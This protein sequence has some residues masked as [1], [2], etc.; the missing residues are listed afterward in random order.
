M[1][2]AGGMRILHLDSG[3]EMRGGQWQVC[4][5]LDGL[6]ARGVNGTLLA[7]ADGPLYELARRQGWHVEPLSVRRALMALGSHDVVHAHDARMHTWASLMGRRPLV[8]SRRV[9]FPVKSRWKYA[10]ADRYL[11]VSHY[12]KSVLVAAGISEDRIAVV[13]D[14]VPVLE[15]ARP[16]IVMAP[17]NAHDPMKGAPLVVAAARAGGIPVHYSSNLEQDLTRASLFVYITH[18]EGL[19]SGVLLAM[20]AGVPVVAS[21]VGGL[22]EAV[23]HGETGLLVENTPSAILDAVRWLRDNAE[24]ARRMGRAG[25]QVVQGEFTVDKMVE[26]TIEV[27][28]QVLS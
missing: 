2:G 14:G 19:G 1:S 25:R 27:Y 8:V 18:S 26:R 24:E 11:A 28:R 15:Q 6:A 20:S 3:R 17:A 13:H 23:R 10:R 5:L 22:P 9:A 12:V 21:N 4:R 7:R 16:A